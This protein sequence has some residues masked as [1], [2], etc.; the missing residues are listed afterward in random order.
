LVERLAGI[1]LQMRTRN[2][3]AP[4]RAV[5]GIDFQ[6]TAGD[7]RPVVLAD[8]VSLREIGIEIVLAREDRPRLDP[9][10][11]REPEAHRHAHRLPVQHREDAWQAEIEG[12][13]LRI[14]LG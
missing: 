6:R 1:L 10:A 2:A 9:G 8:L 7:D 4:P 14:R 13:G 5:A 12:T 3:D 11:D